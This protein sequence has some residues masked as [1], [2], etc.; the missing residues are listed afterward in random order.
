MH[1]EQLVEDMHYAHYF[2]QEEHDL[3]DTVVR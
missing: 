3:G 1:F 2:A